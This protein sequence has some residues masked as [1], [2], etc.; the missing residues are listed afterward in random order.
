MIPLPNPTPYSHVVTIDAKVDIEMEL[1][2]LFMYLLERAT[3]LVRNRA[4]TC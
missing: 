3:I 1:H 2:E 4:H